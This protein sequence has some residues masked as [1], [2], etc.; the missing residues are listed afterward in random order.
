MCKAPSLVSCCRCSMAP[1]PLLSR[2]FDVLMVLFFA[3]HIPITMFIDS[4]GVLPKTWYPEG[5][6]RFLDSYVDAF[7]DP[8]A[9]S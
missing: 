8:L 7:G 4:Q 5:A 1:A 3:S 2:P 9:S 6:V